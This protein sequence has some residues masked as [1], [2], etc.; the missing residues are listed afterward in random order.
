MA[1]FRLNLL[2]VYSF[3]LGFILS[4]LTRFLPSKITLSLFKKLS[5]DARAIWEFERLYFLNNNKSNQILIFLYYFF[6]PVGKGLAWSCPMEST[7]RIFNLVLAGKHTSSDLVKKYI[8]LESEYIK[9]N[10]ETHS[11]NN[12]ILFNYLGLVVADEMYSIY[13]RNYHSKLF[14]EIKKQFNE[15]GTNF[16]AS[17]SYHAL[18]LESIFL[19][20]YLFPGIKTSLLSQF[21]FS[22]ALRF[23]RVVS[24][25]EDIF[26]I[27]DDDSSLCVPRLINTLKPQPVFSTT[28][29]SLQLSN[30]KSFES[31]LNLGVSYEI[32]EVEEF[33]DFGLVAINK[34]DY[35][36]LFVNTNLGQEG[37]GGHNHN[38]LLSI[39][40]MYKKRDFIVD[41]GVFLYSVDRNKNRS[42]ATHSSPFL[43]KNGVKIE[44]RRFV[45]K[46]SLG[47]VMDNRIIKEEGCVKG[48]Y[49]VSDNFLAMNVSRAIT[50]HSH[51]IDILDS[52]QVE[53]GLNEENFQLCCNIYFSNKVNVS[54]LS[55]YEFI[56]I[57]D[58]VK[59]LLS[60]SANPLVDEKR[61]TI[62]LEYSQI[63]S[64][65]SLC[66]VTNERV[67]KWKIKLI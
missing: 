25:A 13:Q 58:G 43:I 11:N 1:V 33:K 56:L 17:T 19:T 39:C 45:N 21:N 34:G 36:A 4:I 62:S 65:S 42:I 14:F 18:V 20:A 40:F 29:K 53:P 47:N 37:K 8:L 51:E 49:T 67:L 41:P 10:L 63:S 2:K 44:P 46:F 27:G 38:D 57:N 12:H 60:F 48:H 16:E 22:R 50:Y 7:Y 54:R 30:I 35:K 23:L 15:D 61:S 3:Y 9:K 6:T 52:F 64:S 31:L 55:K 24:S 5:F 59:V 66:V 28:K 32:S 26:K